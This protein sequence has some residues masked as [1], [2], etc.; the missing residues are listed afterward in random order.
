[1]GLRV[2]K[3]FKRRGFD[4][5]NVYIYIYVEDLVTRLLETVETAPLP[6]S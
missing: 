2:E 4:S 6:L 3:G 1:M 5:I